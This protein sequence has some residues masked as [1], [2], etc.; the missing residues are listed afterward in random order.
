MCVHDPLIEGEVVTPPV[1]KKRTPSLDKVVHDAVVIEPMSLQGED[2][3]FPPYDH[4][5]WRYE[6][7]EKCCTCSGIFFALAQ[8]VK[9]HLLTSPLRWL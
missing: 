9:A 3:L 6:L 2:S 1:G 7:C 4:G 5:K 8:Y